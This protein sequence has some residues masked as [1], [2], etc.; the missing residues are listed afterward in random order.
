MQ[1]IARIIYLAF[2][3]PLAKYPG[4]FCPNSLVLVHLIMLGEVTFM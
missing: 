3:H 1:L 4:P 2:F